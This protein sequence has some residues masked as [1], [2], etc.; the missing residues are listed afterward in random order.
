MAKVVVAGGAG[1]LGSWLCDR[2]IK[3]GHEVL[4]LDNLFTGYKRNI[5]HLIEHKR[6]T[7][8]RWDITQPLKFEADQVYN[9]A[10]PASPV[11]YRYD[12]IETTKISFL[13]TL[14][15]AEQALRCGAK[16]LQA[17]TSEVY[18]D[19]MQHP[20]TEEYFGN[21]N[22]IGPRACYDEG[23]R[24]AESLLYDFQRQHGL[25]VQVARIFN[26]YGP[27]TTAADGRVVSNFV[28]QAVMGEPLV[29][30]GTGRQTRSFCYVSDL[31]EGLYRLM[32][33]PIEVGP[34][35]I[36]NPTEYPVLHLA[37]LVVELAESKSDIVF[38][39]RPIDD[40]ELR[41]PDIT[42][43][44]E[45]LGWEPA[46]DVHAGLLKTINAFRRELLP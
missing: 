19:P 45:V 41:R 29:V 46:V 38:G 24:V 28:S 26:T 27:R 23:K 12:G 13:G 31:I 22:P 9:L 8:M 1:F 15:L 44:R 16:F 11:A 2:L 30:H 25:F 21:V 4:C 40:P 36:G 43:A 32:N 3:E 7:F 37:E 20:Q 5:A 18:G 42:K 33:H 35:N 6:F 17:S 39:P 10:C 34:V 14:N